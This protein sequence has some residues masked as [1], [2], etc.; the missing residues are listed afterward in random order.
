[1]AMAIAVFFCTDETKFNLYVFAR[2]APLRD[3]T[4]PFFLHF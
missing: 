1:M 2:I 4:V 3:A